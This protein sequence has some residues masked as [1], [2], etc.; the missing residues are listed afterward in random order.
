MSV[1]ET[2]HELP[3]PEA[4]DLCDEAS[5]ESIACDVEGNPQAHVAGALVHLARQ[6]A[7]CCY[8]ELG[9]DV[10]GRQGHAFEVSRV[11][12]AHQNAP[13][14]R[15]LF[16]LPNDVSQLVYSLPCVISMHGV[17]SCPE[18]TPLK[19]VDRTKVPLF[20]VLQAD[21]VEE[22]SASVS[23][24]DSNLFVTQVLGIRVTLDKP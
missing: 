3:A 16:D 9:K 22:L 21:L 15:I 5:K 4:G 12:G 8:V 10:A 17:I 18:V 6:A 19:S 24:P 11:P 23:V 20:P 14:C 7:V 13:A 1:S 2:V